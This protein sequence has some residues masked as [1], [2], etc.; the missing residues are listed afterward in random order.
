M[1]RIRPDGHRFLTSL[2]ALVLDSEVP[3]TEE[4]GWLRD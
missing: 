1:P 4:R 2:V 3:R